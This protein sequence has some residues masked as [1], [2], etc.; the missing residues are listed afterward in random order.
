[1]K[2]C[3]YLI[4]I[5]AAR[6]GGDLTVQA[7]PAASAISIHAAREGGDIY[8]L[9]D[10]LE[11]FVISIHAAREGGDIKD[12]GTSVTVPRFQSTPPVKAAT[13]CVQ[14][15]RLPEDISIHAAREGGDIVASNLSV[16][17][18][19]FQ[20]TP[21]VKAATIYCVCCRYC[22]IFQST[23]PVKAATVSGII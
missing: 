8:A 20:S 5:H 11:E 16:S 10:D 12:G 14:F 13:F 17:I 9:I 18:K 3:K 22:V 7:A 4:S 2:Y 1:M 23:P 15:R 19:T 6:E 21:P